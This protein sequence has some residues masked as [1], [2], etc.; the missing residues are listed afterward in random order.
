ML[1]MFHGTYIACIP[2]EY[3]YYIRIG[4]V[5]ADKSRMLWLLR[6]LLTSARHTGQ[7]FS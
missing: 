5:D 6:S 2:K 7:E 3:K 4:A 1:D